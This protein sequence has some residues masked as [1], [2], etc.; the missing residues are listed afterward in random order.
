M[1]IDDASPASTVLTEFGAGGDTRSWR[2][3]TANAAPSMSGP[4]APNGA[5]GMF[6]WGGL[7]AELADVADPVVEVGE[8]CAISESL[9][10]RMTS[11]IR[12]SPGGVMVNGN[13]LAVQDVVGETRLLITKT[14]AFN[15]PSFTNSESLKVT[16]AV[17]ARPAQEA[18]ASDI[19]DDRNIRIVS[20]GFG[21]V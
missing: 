2:T 20:A 14:G 10:N 21:L 5:R 4:S 18:T 3:F 8:E 7:N 15:V 17:F 11:T 19:S 1:A 9:A 13:S 6:D 16:K 12:A